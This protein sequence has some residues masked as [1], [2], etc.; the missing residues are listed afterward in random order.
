[1]L[2]DLEH[3]C[4]PSTVDISIDALDEVHHSSDHLPTPALV[5][6]T[7]IPE[8]LS[9]ERR[10]C[11]DGVANETTGGMRIEREKEDDEEMMCVPEGFK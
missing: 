9:C 11:V 5:P 4:K 10:D 2:N 8:S 3:L 6:N 7:M 1:M